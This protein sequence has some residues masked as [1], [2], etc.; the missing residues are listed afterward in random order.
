MAQDVTLAPRC[1][2]VVT[3]KLD[4]EK[5][6]KIPSLVEHRAGT[7][8]PHADAL[9]RHVGTI[10]GEVRLNPEEVRNGQRKDQFCVRINPGIY[11]SKS[12]FFYNDEGLI[13]RRQRNGKHQLLVPR[14]LISRVIRENHDPAYAAHPGVRRTCELLV[15]NFWWPGIR[16]TVEEYVRE[17]D[18][19]QGQ[20]GFCEYRAVVKANR[21]HVT[22]KK[23]YHK[24]AK[25][26]SFEVGSY[27]YLFNPARKQG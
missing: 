6:R 19:C 11:S 27:V 8:I 7:K 23:L 26:L 9:S 12:E 18:S 13:Y 25:H 3:A 24:R 1:R 16:R 2:H 21:S 14:E 5:E 17:C 4:L 10:L 20:K 15:L 22:N